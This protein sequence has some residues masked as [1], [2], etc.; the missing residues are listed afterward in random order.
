MRNG[1]PTTSRSSQAG[2]GLRGVG[3]EIERK[4]LVTR[5]PPESDRYP[6]QRVA[7]GYMGA[8]GRSPSEQIATRFAG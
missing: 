4:F 7:Q 8:Q 1:R 5:L 6:H 3:L 2:N